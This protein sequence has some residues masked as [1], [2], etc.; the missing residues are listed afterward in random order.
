MSSTKPALGQTVGTYSHSHPEKASRVG[1]RSDLT[2]NELY[3]YTYLLLFV[4]EL[5]E[6]SVIFSFVL[7]FIN[8]IYNGSADRPLTTYL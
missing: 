5:I 7:H 2:T 6:R 8:I 4:L 3:T 1:P